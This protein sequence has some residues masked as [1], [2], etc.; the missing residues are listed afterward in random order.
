MEERKL[1]PCNLFYLPCAFP[2]PLETTVVERVLRGGRSDAGPPRSLVVRGPELN[3]RLMETY[4]ETRYSRGRRRSRSSP[5]SSS[6]FH[7]GPARLYLS[8][9]PLLPEPLSPSTLC[10]PRRS[11]RRGT[12]DPP[13]FSNLFP[14]APTYLRARVAWTMPLRFVHSSIVSS[15]RRGYGVVLYIFV[16]IVI[17]IRFFFF[18]FLLFLFLFCD[19]LPLR[20]SFFSEGYSLT[21]D[22]IS[23]RL[24]LAGSYRSTISNMK[25]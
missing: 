2:D 3:T 14:L 24:P 16:K 22:G 8:A 18:F 13:T 6:L 12:R 19:R 23:S 20:G 11:S 25:V 7:S 1:S 9:F 21:E 17:K 4:A 10:I 5:R 15:R